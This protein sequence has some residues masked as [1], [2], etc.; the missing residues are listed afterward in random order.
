MSEFEQGNL[1]DWFWSRFQ[2]QKEQQEKAGYK[3]IWVYYRLIEERVL[4][5][6]E[7]EFLAKFFNYKP[8]WAKW[9]LQEQL[10]ERKPKKDFK[11]P[12]EEKKSSKDKWDHKKDQGKQREGHR[13]GFQNHGFS[14]DDKISKAVAF[15]EV[16]WPCDK[17]MLKSAYRTLA[18][19]LH[20]DAGG[21][22]Q[23][24]LKLSDAYELLLK[25]VS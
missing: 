14:Y 4:T 19:K 2:D 15:M 24:F 22:H 13:R 23:E 18:R 17:T 11:E 20:P 1:S 8:G 3:P 12:H 7:L 25:S 16:S 21:S 5:L 10:D 9:K 6:E